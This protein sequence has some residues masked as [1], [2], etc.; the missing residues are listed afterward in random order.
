MFIQFI[1][2][3]FQVFFWF[4]TLALF[5]KFFTRHI[6][7]SPS[8]QLFY[9][10]GVGYV[11]W[12][13][14]LFVSPSHTLN[15]LI[16]FAIFIIGIISARSMSL[17]SILMLFSRSVLARLLLKLM[18]AFIWTMPVFLSGWIKDG[19]MIFHGVNAHDG[20]WHMALME[21]LASAS[22][23]VMPTF[24]QFSLE[25]YHYL[26]DLSGSEFVRLF[27]IKSQDL[28]F[29]VYPFLFGLLA[30]YGIKKLSFSLLPSKYVLNQKKKFLLEI[31]SG[32][33]LIGGGSLA[34][35]LPLIGLQQSVNE[36]AFWM[37]QNI[38]TWVNLPLGVSFSLFILTLNLSILV[39]R[40]PERLNVALI[41]FMIGSHLG[42]KAYGGVLLL[43]GG[44]YMGAWLLTKRLIM[45]AMI[46]LF[47]CIA[48]FLVVARSTLGSPQSA[49]LEWNPGW[50]VKTMFE[51]SDRINLPRWELRRLSYEAQS[52]YL[53]LTALWAAGI[54]VFI[55]GNMGSR[56][57]GFYGLHRINNP[58]KN[59]FIVLILAALLFPLLFSQSG[60]E[61]NTIQFGY[62]AYVLL[63]PLVIVAFTQ[64]GRRE[65]LL[66]LIVGFLAFPTSI[67]TIANQISSRTTNAY[68][69]SKS[70]LLVLEQLKQQ[71]PGS[72]LA[73]YEDKAIIPALSGKPCFYCNQT[74]ADLLQIYSVNAKNIVEKSFD[75]NMSAKEIDEL[76]KIH[77]IMY[78]YIPEKFTQEENSNNFA[79]YF[80]VVTSSG[81]AIIYKR[82]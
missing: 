52:N 26:V 57:I 79:E 60:V 77:H 5:G 36:S 61:W 63:T 55:L 23:R 68:A 54:I 9:G 18:F 17:G 4:L 39:Y 2:P 16:N 21:T 74:Q 41:G 49:G 70:N 34:Y 73:P 19:E 44:V 72:V 64:I 76:M 69:I 32:M 3:L 13:L 28:V 42:I 7:N 15:T 37:H 71:D 10:F 31:F 58:E 27:G 67:F 59:Q 1:A 33:L 14:L 62:Y 46:F 30:L 6:T 20:V 43:L 47:V 65:V 81:D 12:V 24:A 53:G 40:K 66:A 45:F 22:D 8:E 82:K 50:F 56:L 78:L 75:V 80:E 29:R 51:A 38:S 35:I 25:G 11:I 48:S